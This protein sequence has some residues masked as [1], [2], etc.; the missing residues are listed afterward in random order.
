MID[1]IFSMYK[2]A[3]FD[4]IG[5]FDPQLRYAWGIDLETWNDQRMKSPA[6]LMIANARIEKKIRDGKVIV[7][8]DAHYF[9]GIKST[10]HRALLWA[11]QEFKPCM[12]VNNGDAFDGGSISR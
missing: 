2:A 4:S 6:G 8:S 11:I 9:P 7:F 3:W 12:V 1:N 5:W 10:A